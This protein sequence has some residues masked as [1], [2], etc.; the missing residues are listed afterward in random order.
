MTKLNNFPRNGIAEA[1][2]LKPK[3]SRR[4]GP[5]LAM[6]GWS[7]RSAN[8]SL[9]HYLRTRADPDEVPDRLNSHVGRAIVNVRVMSFLRGLQVDK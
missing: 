9:V 6:L 7:P 5:T 3:R 1:R 4:V 8:P 2:K